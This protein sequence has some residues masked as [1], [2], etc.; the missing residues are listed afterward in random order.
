ME[1]FFRSALLLLLGMFLVSFAADAAPQRAPRDVN[2]EYLRGY[3]TAIVTLNFP[4]SARALHVEQGVIYIENIALSNEDK[5]RLQQ[6]LDASGG[7]FVLSWLTL[8][9]WPFTPEAHLFKRFQ[10]RRRFRRFSRA[11]LVSNR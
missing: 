3:A 7:A 8:P 2:D 5:I 4:M 1:V 11:T 9:T 6:L 10:K